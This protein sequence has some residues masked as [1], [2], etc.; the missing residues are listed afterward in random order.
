[1]HFTLCNTCRIQEGN[2]RLQRIT[3]V[4]DNQVEELVELLQENQ[5]ILD[6]WRYVVT[7]MLYSY[8]VSIFITSCLA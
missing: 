6:E 2:A 8:L 3:N 4:Q 1:M 5:E 7:L